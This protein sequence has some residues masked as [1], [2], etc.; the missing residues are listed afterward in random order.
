MGAF[1][2]KVNDVRKLAEFSEHEAI[3]IAGFSLNEVMGQAALRRIRS[4]IDDYN[5]RKENGLDRGTVARAAELAKEEDL[6]ESVRHFFSAFFE[7]KGAKI[8]RT[9]IHAHEHETMLRLDLPS[10]YTDLRARTSMCH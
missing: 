8:R 9:K 2:N 4:L 5:E 10:R 3:E 7:V 6:P 1:E